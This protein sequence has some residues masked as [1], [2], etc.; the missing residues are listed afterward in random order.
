MIRPNR[1]ADRAIRIGKRKGGVSV[2]LKIS[3]TAPQANLPSGNRASIAAKPVMIVRESA[4]G[5]SL[6]ALSVRRKSSRDVM[7]RTRS[8]HWMRVRVMSGF[9][10]CQPNCRQK[11]FDGD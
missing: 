11:C 9:G 7:T 3:C 6:D 4:D 10:S 2:A 5:A 8:F 1:D